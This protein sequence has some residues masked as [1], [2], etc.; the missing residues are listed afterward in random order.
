MEGMKWRSSFEWGPIPDCP[1][2][3]A[4]PPGA[5]RADEPGLF[6]PMTAGRPDT[7]STLLM[8]RIR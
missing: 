2:T 3:T 8:S 4:L 5:K 7:V 6:L 1:Q